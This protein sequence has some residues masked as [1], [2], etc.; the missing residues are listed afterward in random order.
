MTVGDGFEPEVLYATARTHVSRVRLADG[1][2]GTVAA[3]RK[4]PLG[5]GSDQR[6]RYELTILARLAD[7]EGVPHLADVPSPA[8][9]ILL[10][11][12]GGVSMAQRRP[13]PDRLIPVALEV[14]TVVA[15]MHRRGVVHKDINPANLLV[16]GSSGRVCLID[17]DLASTFAEERPDFTHQSQITGTLAYL[18]PEQTGRMG[19]PVDLRADL[20]A[21][22]ATLYEFATGGPPFGT[23]DALR[24]THDHLARV[25][26]PAIE[27][28]PA[29]PPALSDIIARLL[30]KEPDQRYQ[31][32]EG[33]A[34]DLARLGADPAAR[35][36]LGERDF[37]MRLAPPSRLV[38][39]DAEIAALRC[40]FA[41]AL[42]GTNRGLL[43]SGGPGV[44]KTAL[45]DEL[46][47]I[48]AGSG[49]WFVSGKF[50]QHRQD[51]QADAVR[52]ALRALGR[53]LLA[54]PPAEAARRRAQLL[55]L[56]GPNAGL[57]AAVLPEFAVLLG[58]PPE[59]VVG[60]AQHVE[61]R[62]ASAGLDLVRAVAS[63]E[64]PLV[65][66]I[67]DLQWALPTPL[68]FVDA[69]L[70]DAGL[71]GVLLVGSYRDAEVDAAHPLT[72][73]FARWQRLD[74][75]PPELRLRNLPPADL[76]LMLA[77]MLRVTPAEG[78]RLAAVV[79]ERTGGN[80]YDTVELINSLRR[81]GALVSGAK[82]WTWEADTVR[83]H[84]GRG[85]V[86]ELLLARIG[87]LP[88]TTQAL[89]EAMACLGGEVTVD[90]LEVASG[91]T[92]D[93][94]QEGLRPALEDGLL[95]LDR[96]GERSVRF[97]HDRVQQ[98]AYDH[99]GK[100]WRPELHL[101]LARRLAARPGF[102]AV[103][104]GQYLYAVG[105]V[106]DPQERRRVV[107]L[108]RAGAAQARMLTNHA[109]AERF[110]AAAAPL[111]D[112]D[113][114]D[115]RVGVEIER[116]LT[117]YSLGRLEAADESY[118]LVE[119]DCAD[120]LRLAEATCVQL[121]S[122]TN[123]GRPQEAVALGL[124]RLRAL[125]VAVPG[126][127]ELGPAIGAG[128][129]ALHGW[130]ATGS[131]ADDLRHPEITDPLVLTTARL[132]NRLTPAAFFSDQAVM[133]WLVLESA[134]I[135]AA[136]GPAG[137]LVG[138]L[139]HAAFVTTAVAQDYRTGCRAVRRVLA[140]GEARGYE[141]DT[142][143][144]R[145]LYAL[146]SAAWF[147]P[148]DEAVH[149]ANLAHEGLVRGGDLHNACF[150]FYASL[151][152]SIDCAANLD[153][154]RGVAD[155]ALAFC[156]RT[157][158]EFATAGYAAYRQLIRALCG[159][160]TSPGRLDDATFDLD[161]RLA[162]CGPNAVGVVNLNIAG[163]L[164]A[165]AYGN[166]AALVRHAAAAM[167]VLGAVVATFATMHAHLMQALA[168]ATR[169]RA[170]APAQAA[171]ILAEL[172]E[173]RS[174][175]AARAADAPANFGHLLCLVDAERAWA[176]GDFHAAATAFDAAQQ[177]VARRERPWHRALI[178]YRAA[179]FY[180]AHGMEHVGQVVL[181]EARRWFERWGATGVVRELDRR[182]P[183][184][185]RA[186]DPTSLRSIDAT[187]S[188]TLDTDAI[189]LIGV[190]NA[191]QALSS[192]TKLHRL[193][194]RVVE[195]LGAMTGATTVRV[196]LWSAD[197]QAWFL[198]GVEG[199]DEPIPLA[200]AEARG[201]MPMSLFHYAERLRE[202]ILVADAAR[203]DRFAGDP[204]V[205][206]LEHCSMLAV[207]VATRGELQAI[208][209]LENRLSRGSFTADRLDAVMLVAGQ[210]A[211]SIDN[212]LLYA[213]LE[214]KVAERT[215]A[216]AEA[217]QRLEVLSIT[218]PLTDLPN[219]RRLTE[220]FDAEWRRAGQVHGTIAVAMIDIDQFK[221]YNDHYG[222]PG[223][224]KCL[225]LV[226]QALRT[227]IRDT[228]LVARYGGEEFAV[229]LP[230]ADTAVAYT[231]AE[232]IR[233][234]VAA[235]REPHERSE[236]GYV[237]VS[238]GVAATSAI[239]GGTPQHLIDA[240]DAQ[241]YQAKRGGRNRVVG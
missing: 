53:M 89:L 223:G 157:G 15:A 128:L 221:P 19:R 169:V 69:V 52:Q 109:L 196:V 226:A 12:V 142:S 104:A 41:D 117:L 90:L 84:L 122:L 132:V 166:D 218:D 26:A 219:R 160:T 27:L 77:E 57:V 119:R 239:E 181:G 3:I 32:A 144:G 186:A 114:V 13:E 62:L 188:T 137:P 21:L 151:P 210:L 237:T 238:I 222:H 91:L 211:V 60:D 5:P 134:R 101:T 170:A 43:I 187:R 73:M 231:V 206:G 105:E 143:Q 17:F 40:A 189:D 224:D 55:G 202:P 129:A 194:A 152:L 79:N 11:D 192:E 36:R 47:S 161:E 110:I 48:V 42:T 165:A 124:D 146:G 141:P 85:D 177:E 18:A 215:E 154:Y 58:V 74:L 20:Y 145:F 136:H 30:E 88:A 118:R 130:L 183:L 167:R 193:R 126:P 172:D 87:A 2:G 205:A 198:P 78:G 240:A 213:A 179:Q 138:P 33:L 111:V 209:L 217:N 25:P 121:S 153:I 65:L 7:V 72:A 147:G 6:V 66:V 230:G 98:A 235:L 158:N 14:A 97:R 22:G 220:V 86:V 34:H 182:Y 216:L 236:H 75:A 133:A 64:R 164:A 120:P 176:V 102:D 131:E 112:P 67:D 135:W 207:P 162:A 70:G 233:A 208:V 54:E 37:P 214:R 59:G 82:G 204:Y 38:G 103:A 228:D 195:V 191:S 51:H 163:A 212:A 49:G 168:L 139:S 9:V 184:L 190:V 28:N 148:L 156:A 95:V 125:G 100:Q 234:G 115:T 71:S 10:A 173:C 197:A 159:E 180:L 76:G 44:G 199:E 45:T 50:D 63:P 185:R 229:I 23:G 150:T 99:L 93:E 39:R 4:E 116:H 24:L 81:E 203:D 200:E 96:G 107:E 92:P 29:L 35:F 232:R 1:T 46:R 108:L 8:G 16:S 80:P 56:L 123:Q 175:L 61:I 178:A 31:S 171:P 127:D 155:S 241:L 94:L 201:I 174:W 113:D 68:G 227:C 225:Q 140:A 106:A 83:R 149:Q